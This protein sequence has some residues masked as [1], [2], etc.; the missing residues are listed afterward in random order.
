MDES[1]GKEKEKT[2][3]KSR[4]QREEENVKQRGESKKERI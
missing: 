1:K 4:M 3:K 2:I